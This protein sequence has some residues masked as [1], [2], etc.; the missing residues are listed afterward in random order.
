[1]EPPGR[2][3]EHGWG[4]KGGMFLFAE[5]WHVLGGT[6]LPG[7]VVRLLQKLVVWWGRAVLVSA[8]PRLS[9]TYSACSVHCSSSSGS[10]GAHV[11]L[12]VCFRCSFVLEAVPR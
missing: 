2:E 8:L 10:M 3:G 1:M 6:E 12:Q 4:H 11:H 7:N 9:T 5:C